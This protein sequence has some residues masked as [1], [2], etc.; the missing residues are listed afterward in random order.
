MKKSPPKT[1]KTPYFAISPEIWLPQPPLVEGKFFARPQFANQESSNDA[2]C[3]PKTR[4]L[5]SGSGL[6]SWKQNV[7][8]KHGMGYSMIGPA[9]A[10][11][12]IIRDNVVSPTRQAE[13][14][15][16]APPSVCPLE[17]NPAILWS[18]ATATSNGLLLS[19]SL[20][21]ELLIVYYQRTIIFFTYHI[22]R[23]INELW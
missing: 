23:I 14:L 10:Y 3:T 21:F 15:R 6:K 22:P 13:S 4:D 9:E 18:K 16:I 2:D 17:R 8:S 5:S 11:A 12:S 7:D 20:S 1:S 19:V